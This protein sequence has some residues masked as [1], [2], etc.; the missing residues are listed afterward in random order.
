MLKG[1]NDNKKIGRNSLPE[2]RKFL[3]RILEN[4]H[5]W[6]LLPQ[7]FFKKIIAGK[8]PSKK[9]QATTNVCPLERIPPQFTY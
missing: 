6:V 8:N 7:V 5:T 4:L 3:V 1:E 9:E 2:E